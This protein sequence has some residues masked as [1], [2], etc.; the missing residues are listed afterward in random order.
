MTQ[1]I[2]QAKYRRK[3]KARFLNGFKNDK[4]EQSSLLAFMVFWALCVI[5]MRSQRKVPVVHTTG[6]IACKVSVR[7]DFESDELLAA[8][9][10][11]V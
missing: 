7:H 6:T 5:V 8:T 10:H 1:T 11:G 3:K 2:E 4:H 9:G